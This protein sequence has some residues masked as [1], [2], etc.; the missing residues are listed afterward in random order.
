MVAPS[1]S[2]IQTSQPQ[3]LVKPLATMAENLAGRMNRLKDIG[4]DWHRVAMN[5]IQGHSDNPLFLQHFFEHLSPELQ[6]RT[7]EF[8]PE[9]PSIDHQEV[10][11]LFVDVLKVEI[12]VQTVGTSFNDLVELSLQDKEA[13]AYVLDSPQR[14][15]DFFK[16]RINSILP[17][18]IKDL[19]AETD[20]IS[21]VRDADI[22]D[23]ETQT[24]IKMAV[25]KQRICIFVPLFDQQK[26]TLSYAVIALKG[27]YKNYKMNELPS[28]FNSFENAA[29]QS[30][31]EI[32]DLNTALRIHYDIYFDSR[33]ETYNEK[34]LHNDLKEYF[35]AKSKCAM[36]VGRFSIFES[37][38]EK[39]FIP[40]L[41][42]HLNRFG[43]ELYT[44]ENRVIAVG[45]CS[46]DFLKAKLEFCNS[47]VE[48]L[49]FN[50]QK[51]KIDFVCYDDINASN[52]LSLDQILTSFIPEQRE[53][54]GVVCAKIENK[55]SV[56]NPLNAERGLRKSLGI[57]NIVQNTP[58]SLSMAFEQ[59]VKA[60]AGKTK[61][62]ENPNQLVDVEF[63]ISEKN[64]TRKEIISLKV[65][66]IRAVLER[67]GKV[68]AV[69]RGQRQLDRPLAGL[70]LSEEIEAVLILRI[71]ALFD[72][73]QNHDNSNHRGPTTSEDRPNV[74]QKSTFNEDSK[75]GRQNQNQG[76]ATDQEL[77]MDFDMTK[78]QRH[79]H[80]IEIPLNS[81]IE[82]HIDNEF[83][84]IQRDEFGNIIVLKG[85]TELSSIN[86][87]QEGANKSVYLDNNNIW[88]NITTYGIE[89]FNISGHEMTL[90]KPNKGVK[91]YYTP[92]RA[93]KQGWDEFFNNNEEAA[94]VLENIFGKRYLTSNE[95][96]DFIRYVSFETYR[97]PII[98]EDGK[99]IAEPENIFEIKHPNGKTHQIPKEM[100]EFL[101][102]LRASYLLEK[103]NFLSWYNAH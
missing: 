2:R 26:N 15:L 74:V 13:A 25:H 102:S 68:R 80:N 1:V 85:Q 20:G 39:Q 38:S 47:I 35:S 97:L 29:H 79:K 46:A 77:E 88:I 69:D 70:A 8:L 48:R 78:L 16:E 7:L 40:S 32:S 101:W 11:E 50:S 84:T 93:K 51:M 18:N 37:D 64:Q 21:V 82:I 19:V 67:E 92:N 95:R 23:I 12:D 83:F 44:V 87:A 89:I 31:E 22:P 24:V 71:C 61:K 55:Q 30:S 33:S 27:F 5:A 42:S 17:Q 34:A 36:A 96:L 59:I 3:T 58:D 76:F 103:G 49:G 57:K 4:S 45:N 90:L 56:I 53:A 86:F 72:Q 75:Q 52:F 100:Y 99:E 91:D 62:L 14:F 98:G 73:W 43:I 63:S 54:T 10:K 66:Q 28:I 9:I 81:Y 60:N 65:E 94:K 41:R 6:L